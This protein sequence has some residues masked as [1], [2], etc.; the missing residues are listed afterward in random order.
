M[1]KSFCATLVILF[2]AINSASF[3][4]ARVKPDEPQITQVEA[5]EA[6]E[7]AKQFTLQFIRSRDLA[8]I[9]KDLYWADFIER[10][11]AFTSKDLNGNSTDIL[12][13]SGLDYN[14]RLLQEGTSEDWQRFYIAANNFLLL[15][16]L[17]GLK[18]YSVENADIK[19]TDIYP[20]NVIKLLDKNPNLANMIVRKGRSKA[21]GSVEEMRNATATLEQAVSD[22]RQKEPV[23]FLAGIEKELVRVMTEDDFFGPRV[24]V[25]D[26]EVFGFPKGARIISIKTPIGLVLMLAR[27]SNRLKIFSTGIIAE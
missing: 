23:S 20:S 12:L 9:V 15:G 13:V 7:V 17:A 27:D 1:L 24:E 19:A 2:L 25:T 11:K 8:P 5:R 21:V 4:L 10:Y 14:S 26:Q 16:F 3:A 18:H 22:V 6:R